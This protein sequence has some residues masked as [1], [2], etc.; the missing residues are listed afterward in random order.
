MAHSGRPSLA[1]EAARQALVAAEGTG[2]PAM[3]LRAASV[4]LEIVPDE[5]VVTAGKSAAEATA[6]GLPEGHMRQHFLDSAV[7]KRAGAEAR[8]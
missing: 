1:L 2:D 8:A 4:V 7:A 6:S 3:R 5:A